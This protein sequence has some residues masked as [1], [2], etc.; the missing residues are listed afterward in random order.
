MEKTPQKRRRERVTAIIILTVAGLIVAGLLLYCI[1]WPQRIRID[2]DAYRVDA[3][4]GGA[5]SYTISFDATRLRYAFRDDRLTGHIAIARKESGDI[6]VD[7]DI[8]RKLW[9]IQDVTR[10]STEDATSIFNGFWVEYPAPVYEMRMT[11][12]S[13]VLS[14]DGSSLLIDIHGDRNDDVGMYV[15]PTADEQSANR[16]KDEFGKVVDVDGWIAD[17]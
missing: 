6:V 5:T 13:G 10:S 14:A 2:G 12:V 11:Q 9:I 16:L 15:A 3:N 17:D 1:P 8:D 7:Q 4:A